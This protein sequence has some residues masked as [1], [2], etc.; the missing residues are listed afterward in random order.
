MTMSTRALVLVGSIVAAALGASAQIRE[1]PLE[2]PHLSGQS[3][4]GAFE[5]WFTNADGSFSLLLGYYNRNLEEEVDIPI[6]ENNRIEPGGPDLGQPTHFMSGRMWGVFIVT[7]PRDFGT[8][9]LTWTIVAHGKPTEIPMS[10]DPLWEIAP[11]K[12]AIGNTPPFLSYRSFA[13]GGA[14]GQGPRAITE[15]IKAKVPTPLELVVWVAD[16]VKFSPGMLR[17]KDPITVSWSK[18]RGPGVVTFANRRPTVAQVQEP[19]PPPA[20]FGGKA[21]TSV[22]FSEPGEYTLYLVVNDA[23]GVGGGGFQCCWTNGF[24]NVSVEPAGHGGE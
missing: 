18:F 23:S 13:S 3:I 20:I 21:S 6:G 17:P 1:L 24:V 19:L 22:S 15:S 4:T 8:N 7:V 10:L 9:K 11:L 16:D 14:S 5:G 2:P 12:D